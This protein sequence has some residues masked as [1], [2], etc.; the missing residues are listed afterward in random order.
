ML[1]RLYRTDM[2]RL[3]MSYEIFRNAMQREIDRR[4]MEM[5]S[6]EAQHQ[7]TYHNYQP[8]PPTKY[9]P[10]GTA[11]FIN[12]SSSGVSSGVEAAVPMTSGLSKSTSQPMQLNSHLYNNFAHQHH[13]LHQHNMPPPPAQFSS[14]SQPI[15]STSSALGG[16]PVVKSA[17]QPTAAPSLSS[18]HSVPTT[19][20]T[21]NLPRTMLAHSQSGQNAYISAAG[22]GQ[23]QLLQQHQHAHQLPLGK[24]ISSTSMTSGHG[25]ILESSSST[26]SLF[27]LNGSHPYLATSN[28]SIHSITSSSSSLA[29][30][31]TS[32]VSGL[33]INGPSQGQQ[34]QT[35]AI[36][37]QGAG[38]TISHLFS[39]EEETKV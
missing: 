21:S 33:P 6:K 2:E 30:P 23:H 22:G 5:M 8:P 20:S 26:S 1:S 4:M 37:Q 11:A 36:V 32:N 10:K 12:G 34:F 28:S 18:I 19:H 17:S 9:I 7:Q 27:S 14:T 29:P 3:V 24:T 15:M 35:S 16:G 25:S 38:L 31:I 39:P 13:L